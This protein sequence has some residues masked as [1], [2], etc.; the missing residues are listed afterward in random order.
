MMS[1]WWKLCLRNRW[2]FD[3]SKPVYGEMHRRPANDNAREPHEEADRGA[4]LAAAPFGRR[5]APPLPF[6][7]VS[8]FA[9]LAPPP[10]GARP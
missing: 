9:R 6:P 5:G 3:C 1:H 7:P 2:L 4:S 10:G 8:L